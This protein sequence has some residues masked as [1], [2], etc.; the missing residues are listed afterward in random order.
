MSSITANSITEW[1]DEHRHHAV[2]KLAFAGSYSAGGLTLNFGAAGVQNS[3]VPDIVE[4]PF[5]RGYSFEYVPGTDATD[6]KLKV[7]GGGSD[8]AATGTLTSDN[9][10][11]ANNATVTI[12]SET[13]TFKTSLTTSTTAYEVLIGSD[14]D[15]SL[16]NLISAINGTG[17]PGT[18]YGSLTPVNSSVS[19]ASSVTSHAFAV[20]AL[21]SGA[22]GNAIATTETSAHLSWGGATLSG[23]T[24]ATGT[25]AE[26]AA[27]AFPTDLASFTPNFHAIFPKLQ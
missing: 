21:I 3:A 19:A 9:T 5:Y 27:S 25:G 20:T 6:G 4:T 18:D 15:G 22:A 14:A 8:V 13:Y 1:T 10:N 11:V 2:G 7:Y 24:D 16:L 17:T 26:L 23:G 12:G